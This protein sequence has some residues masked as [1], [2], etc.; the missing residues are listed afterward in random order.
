MKISLI[1]ALAAITGS[2]LATGRPLYA[3]ALEFG[4][5][6]DVYPRGAGV[7]ILARDVKLPPYPAHLHGQFRAMTYQGRAAVK[8]DWAASAAYKMSTLTEGE[9]SKAWERVQN[10]HKGRANEH[11]AS[12]SNT[13]GI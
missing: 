10:R 7:T 4:R 6:L 11:R 3:N 2:A 13:T 1:T 12:R 9:D 5:D 8:N